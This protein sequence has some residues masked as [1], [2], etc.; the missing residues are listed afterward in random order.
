MFHL[1]NVAT[2]GIDVIHDYLIQTNVHMQKQS[3][4]ALTGLHRVKAAG[5]TGPCSSFCL[6]SSDGFSVSVCVAKI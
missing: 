4:A 1:S 6:L 5:R 3:K 2:N